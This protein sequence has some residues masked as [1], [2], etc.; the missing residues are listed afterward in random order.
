MTKPLVDITALFANFDV[1]LG[2]VELNRNRV[3]DNITV[4]LDLHKT[5]T[6]LS[7]RE[8]DLLR[9][10]H[11]AHT[12]PLDGLDDDD[13]RINVLDQDEGPAIAWWSTLIEAR[14]QRAQAML[15]TLLREHTPWRG[16][17]T[18]IVSYGEAVPN[19]EDHRL[20]IDL[21]RAGVAILDED[22]LPELVGRRV[23]IVVEDLGPAEPSTEL[24]DQA[25]PSYDPADDPHYVAL[26][27]TGFFGRQGSG[28]VAIARST[29]RMLLMLR[30]GAVLEPGTYGNCGGAHHADEDPEAA[31]KREVREETGWAG[32]DAD[33]GIIP[34]FVFRSGDFVYRNHFVLVP[35]EFTPLYGWEAVGHVWTTPEEALSGRLDAPLHFGIEA[36]LADPASLAIAQGGWRG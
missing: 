31:A 3:V 19:A 34:A 4:H 24:V 11:D 15:D 7:E 12:D 30:S 33:L 1:I 32:P 20:T 13:W 27:E 26:A 2:R 25:P 21:G 10:V 23:R 9:D 18:I 14:S 8:V 6:G 22:V 36:L 17:E 29:G 5:I 28:A 35:D 16:R